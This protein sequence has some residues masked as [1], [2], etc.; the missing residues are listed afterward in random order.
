MNDEIMNSLLLKN[1]VAYYQLGCF[2]ETE[3]DPKILPLEKTYTG[4]DYTAH[5]GAQLNNTVRLQAKAGVIIEPVGNIEINRESVQLPYSQK[6]KIST[7]TL[8]FPL[9]FLL[10]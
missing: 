5:I 1:A 8:G 3:I 6:E 4:V 9:G 2:K 7:F 10:K